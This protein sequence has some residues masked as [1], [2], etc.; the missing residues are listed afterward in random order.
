[1]KGNAPMRSFAASLFEAFSL[2]SKCTIRFLQG[3][4]LLRLRS[5]SPA[6]GGRQTGPCEHLGGQGVAQ[7]PNVHRWPTDLRLVPL[8]S[9][10]VMGSPQTPGVH[11]NKSVGNGPRRQ[12]AVE[13]GS[14]FYRPGC[15]FSGSRF[16][17]TTHD[18]GGKGT[19]PCPGCPPLSSS[20]LPVSSSGSA[21]DV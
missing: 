17:E 4:R 19:H 21:R 13:R 15:S 3:I 11:R 12:K 20:L 14:Q 1:L 6:A 9:W 7:D 16:R 10:P 18:V 2:Y 5:S 8:S